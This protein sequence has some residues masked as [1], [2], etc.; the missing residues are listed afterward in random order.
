MRDHIH[1]IEE[2]YGNRYKNDPLWNEIVKKLT[3]RQAYVFYYSLKYYEKNHVDIKYRLLDFP[4]KNEIHRFLID[5]LKTQKDPSEAA[6]IIGDN[7]HRILINDNDLLWIRTDLRAA[8]WLSYF[9][10]TSNRSFGSFFLCYLT[11]TSEAELINRLIHTIDIYGCSNRDNTTQILRGMFD[12]N[13]KELF[14]KFRGAFNNYRHNYI[15]HRIND[16]HLNWI[17]KLPLDEVDAILKKFIAD[18]ILVLNGTFVPISKKDKIALIKSSLDIRQYKYIDERFKKESID[19]DFNT[20]IHRTDNSYDQSQNTSGNR[21]ARKDF[22]KLSAYEII[23]LLIK[24]RNSRE[25]RKVRSTAK[26]DRN[27]VLTKE[28]HSIIIELSNQL[29]ATPKKIIEALIKNIDLK[30]MYAVSELDKLISGK[31][32]VRKNII[33][34]SSINHEEI[35]DIEGRKKTEESYEFVESDDGVKAKKD[36]E[37]KGNQID[38]RKS[39]REALLNYNRK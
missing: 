9:M 31:R 20:A 39:Q 18:K 35:K 24:A 29:K 21:K 22:A 13:D 6:R 17:N 19:N 8:I 27:I 11:S 38:K 15:Q 16:H 33:L 1:V 30:D 3:V 36:L 2:L 25:Y 12:N 32:S 28:A 37:K 14:I 34:N 7:A 5:T 26:T 10:T 23:D 4:D